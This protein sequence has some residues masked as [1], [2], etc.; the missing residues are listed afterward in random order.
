VKAFLRFTLLY[1]LI[2]NFAYECSGMISFSLFYSSLLLLLDDLF[3][4]FIGA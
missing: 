2:A 3:N 1:L 4:S